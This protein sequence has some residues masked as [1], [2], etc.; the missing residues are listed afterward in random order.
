M[1]LMEFDGQNIFLAGQQAT[2][3]TDQN[4]RHLSLWYIERKLSPC[5]EL[6]IVGEQPFAGE[7][8]FGESPN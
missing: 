4:S 8:I 1:I 6:L 2:K 7:F 5:D 3:P